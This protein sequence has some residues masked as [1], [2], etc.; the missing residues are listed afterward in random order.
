MGYWQEGIAALLG[1]GVNLLLA[2]MFA[3]SEGGQEF[4]RLN[5][6]LGCFNLLP[7]QQLDGGRAL[8][9]MLAYFTYPASAEWITGFLDGV[10]TLVL[11][12]G[13]LLLF[14]YSKNIT[15]ILIAAWI[16]S[17]HLKAKK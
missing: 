7:V 5:L 6:V 17:P 4:S 1:P 15:L 11:L 13:G 14:F 3:W 8:W 12:S 16:V 2:V 9:A 10:F